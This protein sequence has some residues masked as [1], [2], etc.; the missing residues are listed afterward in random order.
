MMLAHSVYNDIMP[1]K[2]F[3]DL[4]TFYVESGN[5]LVNT[6]D[7]RNMYMIKQIIV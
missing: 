2:I 4:M 5:S 1:A 6:A 7:G 3:A